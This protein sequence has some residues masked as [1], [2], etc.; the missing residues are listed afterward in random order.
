MNKIKIVGAVLGLF[1]L[2][3]DVLAKY[4]TEK[5]FPIYYELVHGN[6]QTGMKDFTPDKLIYLM[7]VFAPVSL[8]LSIG[9]VVFLKKRLPKHQDKIFV[10]L[11]IFGV[12][13][14]CYLITIPYF[15]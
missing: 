1:Y 15:K 10:P 9:S 14:S 6:Y 5:T 12:G 3:F 7:F 4:L 13:M 11:L 8:L 2:Y